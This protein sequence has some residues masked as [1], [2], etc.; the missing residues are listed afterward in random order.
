MTGFF[1]YLLAMSF[2]IGCILKTSCM[3]ADCGVANVK[4]G[5]SLANIFARSAF[6]PL[7]LSFRLKPSGTNKVET[8]EKS[9]FMR[10]NSL[11][12]NRLKSNHVY[13]F[14]M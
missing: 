12:E 11:V 9:R 6:F 8:K 13:S 4:A 5:F 1:F 3:F 10:K 14:I 7:S 2:L